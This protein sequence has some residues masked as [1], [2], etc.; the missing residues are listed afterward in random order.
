MLLAG[1]SNVTVRYHVSSTAA[2]SGGGA[3]PGDSVAAYVATTT[4]ANQTKAAF[5]PTADVTLTG[6]GSGATW[7]YQSETPQQVKPVGW[8]QT[9]H[10]AGG[11]LRT[12]DGYSDFAISR[13]PTASG[14]WR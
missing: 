9:L 7:A 11:G 10:P 2:T 12:S 6:W 13:S 4:Y 14:R 8:D 3:T 1:W 5:G